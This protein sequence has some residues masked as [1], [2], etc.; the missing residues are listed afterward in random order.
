MYREVPK[1][2]IRRIEDTPENERFRI[3]KYTLE[4]CRESDDELWRE[5]MSVHLEDLKALNELNQK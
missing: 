3:M 1:R 4:L 2:S 5:L